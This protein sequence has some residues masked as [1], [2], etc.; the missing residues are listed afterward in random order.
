MSTIE[1]V[2]SELNFPSKKK[3]PI[4]LR[5]RQIPFTQ[6]QLED[7]T[8]S[9][10]VNQIYGP[11]PKYEGKITAARMN[12]RWQADLADMTSK[13]GKDGTDHI[14]FVMDIF[15]RRVWARAIKG[16]TAEVVTTAFQ[17]ILE[18][19]GTKPVELN[20]DGGP[21]FTNAFSRMLEQNRINHRRKPSPDSRNDLATL[22]SAMG[23]IKVAI[24]KEKTARQLNDFS[25][26][27]DKVI[28]GYNA[29]PHSHLSDKAPKDVEGDLRL[30]FELRQQAVKDKSH[31]VEVNNKNQDKLAE[32]GAFRTLVPG[33]QFKR[34]DQPR[35]SNEVHTVASQIGSL[36]KDEK[37][38]AY[39]SKLLLPVPAQSR[40]VQTMQFARGGSSRVR[41]A[42]IQALQPY[43]NALVA[44]LQ[45]RNNIS[46]ADASKF[47]RT[48]PGFDV[49][50][51]KVST[52]GEFVRLF[53]EV[54]TLVVGGASGGASRVRLAQ[55]ATRR[56]IV[57][58][59]PNPNS[60]LIV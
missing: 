4:A 59:Q 21:E 26:V 35:Y 28:K 56:R 20:T 14:L 33:S 60:R 3:L 12:E 43:A 48:Q 7:L 53:P 40:T 42:K 29:S 9:N 37:G 6:G 32:Q 55:E 57:G 44:K 15:S 5:A 49:A 22:D 52:C 51:R 27:L 1:E 45:E 10:E 31:N 41:S 16:A 24:E 17:S 34:K 54:L 19:A 36:T 8:R 25:I 30:R 50:F 18:E 39:P 23:N 58:K 47:L 11:P 46:T 13:P 2:Y 38:D